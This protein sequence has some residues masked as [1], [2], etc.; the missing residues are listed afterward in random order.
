MT[1]VLIR[2]AVALQVRAPV[3]YPDEYLTID[4]ARSI[5]A[6]HAGSTR[7]T[8]LSNTYT[9]F[10]VP[11]VQSPLWLI[12][13]IDLSIRLSQGL[14]VIAFA[15]AAFPAYFLGRR[16]GISERGSLVVAVLALL[17]PVGAFTATLMAEPYAYPLFLVTVLLG[18]EAIAGGKAWRISRFS[19]LCWV[20]ASSAVSSFSSSRSRTPSRGGCRGG[21]PYAPS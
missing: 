1:S 12:D 3:F 9:S 18:T 15:T 2:F 16:L 6:G 11:L 10:F 5:A 20:S 13:N 14:G 21:R 17:A 7:G 8:V 4:L 19:P